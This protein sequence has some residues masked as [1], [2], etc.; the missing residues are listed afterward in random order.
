MSDEHI[1]D[2]PGSGALLLAAL[3][4][5]LGFAA[6][7]AGAG[8][9]SG[10]LALLGDAGHMVTDSV[11]LGLAALA[12]WLYRK[13][14][15]PRHSYG[16]QRTEVLMGL[17]N[18]LLMLGVIVALTVA[19]IQ[20]LL[21]PQTVHGE[22]VTLVAFIGLVINILVA[23][24]L[25]RGEQTL[26]TRSA[27][28]HV[29]GDLLGSVAALVSGLVIT[30]TGWMAIDPILT[31]IIAALI[32]ASTIRLLLETLHTL[33]EGVPH[34]FSL[35]AIGRAIAARPNVRSVHDLHLW[36]VSSRQ[37][38]LSAHLVVDDLAQWEKVLADVAATLHELGIDHLTLQPEPLLRQVRWA[39]RGPV[40]GRRG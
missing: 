6:V 4:L 31:L 7:E 30:L 36:T 37:V 16:L 38:A 20:R 13:P 33:M 21:A 9:W 12:A 18:T 25:A 24:M 17:L 29:L 32:L 40:P 15:S 23:W 8:W 2:K 11:S 10:S 22:A 39:V 35:E 34:H 14:P 19:A 1:H 28:L 27:L 26:N 3:G 5:T